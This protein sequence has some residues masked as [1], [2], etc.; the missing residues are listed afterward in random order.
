MKTPDFWHSNSLTSKLLTP[1]GCIYGFLTQLRLKLVKS[2]KIEIP[3]ICVGNITAGGTG[4]TPVSLSLAKMLATEMYHPFFVTRGYGGKL[5]NVIVNNKKHTAQ[6]VGD[7]PLLLS[8]Q[9]PVAVNANR[10]KAA[11]LALQEGADVVIMDDGFQN[12]SLY[13]DLSFLVFDGNYGIGNGK[14]IPAGPLRETFDDGIKR[15]DALIILGK[16]KHNLSERSK[17]PVFFGHTEVV[18]TATTKNDVIAFAGIGHPQKFYRTLQS[19]GLNIVETIDFPDHHFYQKKELEQILHR[20]AEMNADVY[21]TSK[22]FVK[23]P[24][25]M[26]KYINVL[27]IAVVWDEPEKLTAFI[28]EKIKKSAPKAD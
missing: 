27:E 10:Y 9:A 7:E 16:D 24:I 11:Q 6:D 3:V 28:R 4:K 8:Q 17:L 2:P 13:K 12:P 22:D 26:Q 1:I 19:Q 5:Q 18:Q 20:A 15:A 21:T 23:I 14:I 25:S